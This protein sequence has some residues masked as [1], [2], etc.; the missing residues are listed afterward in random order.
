VGCA[1]II[2]FDE[3]RARKHWTT[4]RQRRHEHSDQWLDRLEAALPEGEPTLGRV[5]ETIWVLRQELTGGM[6]ETIVH[7]THPAERRRQQR[8]CPTWARLLPARGPVHRGVETMVG[9]IALERPS[10]YCPVC[11]VGMYPL[12]EMLG[13]CA[14]RRPRDVHQ[15]AVD[16]G[17]R[18]PV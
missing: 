3:V 1:E 10:F 4:L 2:S 11:R 12:D 8:P 6:A 9:A 5:R 18:G 16:L 13:V 14:G 17:H 7:H 15:A